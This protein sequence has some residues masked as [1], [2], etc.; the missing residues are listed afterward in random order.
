MEIFFTAAARNSALENLE[1]LSL[2]RGIGLRA[3]VA[4]AVMWGFFP[5][6]PAD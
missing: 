2:L 3:L 5:T 4:R 6:R 1:V